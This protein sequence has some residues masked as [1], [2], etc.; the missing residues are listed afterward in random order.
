[1]Y[2]I[3]TVKTLE[4]ISEVY[5]TQFVIYVETKLIRKDLSDNFYTFPEKPY[6][7]LELT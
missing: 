5:D 1:M 4:S 3:I 2:N 7:F 6:I